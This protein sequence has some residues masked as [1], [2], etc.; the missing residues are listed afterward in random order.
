MFKLLLKIFLNLLGSVWRILKKLVHG[1][2]RK[3][4]NK[5]LTFLIMVLP[6][7]SQC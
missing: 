2:V 7:F 6:S 4:G 3:K 1:L 5:I